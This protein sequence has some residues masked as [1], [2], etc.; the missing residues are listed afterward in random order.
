MARDAE[1]TASQALEASIG[2]QLAVLDDAS[3]TGVGQSAADALEISTV[4]LTE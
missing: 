1:E 2:A 3:M 4:E